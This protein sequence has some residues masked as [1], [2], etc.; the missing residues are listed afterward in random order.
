MCDLAF[1]PPVAGLPTSHASSVELGAWVAGYCS[2]ACLGL[3]ARELFAVGDTWWQKH[4]REE[5]PNG[6]A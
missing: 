4:E 3:H 1:R 2:T 5:A 6:N